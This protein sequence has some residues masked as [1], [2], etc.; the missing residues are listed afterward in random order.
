[1]SVKE[2]HYL[3]NTPSEIDKLGRLSAMITGE[4]AFVTSCLPPGTSKRNEF[5]F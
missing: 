3:L 1:M 5:A 2:Q 4:T